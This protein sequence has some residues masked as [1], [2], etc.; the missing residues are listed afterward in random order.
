MLY[1][2]KELKEATQ[3]AYLSFL[4][5]AKENLRA[6]G[7]KG[8]FTIRELIQSCIRVNTLMSFAKENGIQESEIT[9]KDMVKFSDLKDSDKEIIE[10]FSTE[11]FEWK[12]ID[13]QDLNETNGFYACCIE[14]SNESAI[15]AFRGSENMQKISNLINDWCRADFGLLNSRSTRQ[16]EEAEKY[17]D[18]L[19]RKGIVDKYKNFAVTGHSLGGNLATH[20]TISTGTESK[21]ELSDKIV[22]SV[23]F[24]G[25][26]FSDEYLEENEEKICRTSDKLTHYKWSAVGD[27]LFDIPGEKT[28]FLAID[29]DLHKDNFIKNIKYKVI[30]RHSTQ[31]LL[32]DEKGKAAKGKQDLVSKG[33]SALSK[34][35]DKFIPEAITT[36]LFA[37]VDWILEK[38]L[39]IKE[40]RKA[41][42]TGV[43]WSERFAEKGSI[44]G[45]CAKFIKDAIEV[46]KDATDVLL[47]GNIQVKNQLKPAFAD[48]Y[49]GVISN[50]QYNISNTNYCIDQLSWGK[51]RDEQVN[52]NDKGSKKIQ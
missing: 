31:S 27:L 48:V 4:A 16:Q 8:P 44:L 15:V 12:I 10:R 17:G 38:T 47:N 42:V 5:D 36:E 21:K 50:S 49:G 22:Q 3:I 25:P 14:T 19:F 43:S 6:D 51:N 30:T 45:T 39:E 13:V 52:G 33:M 26:G 2:D 28:E 46:V 23:N 11:M 24:D 41:K 35:L 32:F 7:R 18:K 9:I 37:A 34:T 29:E 1:T 20:F 40:G